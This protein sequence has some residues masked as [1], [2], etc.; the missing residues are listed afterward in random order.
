MHKNTPLKWSVKWIEWPL[1][2]INL[3]TILELIIKLMKIS[4]LDEEIKRIV[5][6][7]KLK[8]D[9]NDE[10]SDIQDKLISQTFHH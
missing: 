2:K 10:V 4:D 1:T 8:F 6:K 3:V 5:G 7:H 9:D